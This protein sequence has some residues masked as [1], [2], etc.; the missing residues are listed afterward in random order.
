MILLVIEFDQVNRISLN[1][2]IAGVASNESSPATGLAFRIC[3]KLPVFPF[4]WTMI[5]HL[6]IPS[7]ICRRKR[8][9]TESN[10]GSITRLYAD[11]THVSGPTR[12]ERTCLHRSR[13]CCFTR[14]YSSL[15]PPV[16][17]LIDS[18]RYCTL[19]FDIEAVGW[20]DGQHHRRQSHFP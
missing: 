8:T 10:T 15:R 11:A 3:Y 13:L 5:F 1:L 12:N 6:H 16:R 17:V 14:A 9:A 18:R 4:P 2:M 7:H 20:M 19:P